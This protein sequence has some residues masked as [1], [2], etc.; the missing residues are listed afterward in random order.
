[1]S[2]KLAVNGGPPV[3]QE[4]L[5][6]WPWFDEETI[7]FAMEPLKSGKVNYWTPYDI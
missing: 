1:M 5:P 6:G 2:E 7:K 3:I 4:P